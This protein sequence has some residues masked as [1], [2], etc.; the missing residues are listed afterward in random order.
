VASN[1]IGGL[2]RE[3]MWLPRDLLAPAILPC[4][5]FTSNFD[6][7]EPSELSEMALSGNVDSRIGGDK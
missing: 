3:G 5:E 4:P 7:F 1:Q 6:L 2:E